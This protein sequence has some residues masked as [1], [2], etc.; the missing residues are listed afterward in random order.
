MSIQTF[1]KNTFFFKCKNIYSLLL[2]VIKREL[3]FD[4][5]KVFFR[6]H[7]EFTHPSF[8]RFYQ[9]PPVQWCNAYSY[10]LAHWIN[11]PAWINHKPF[12][13]EINDHPLSAVSYMNRAI[14][15]PVDMLNHIQDAKDVYMH[16]LCKKILVPDLGIKVLFR[17]YFGESFNKKVYLVKCPGC[18]P[19]YTDF[20]Q[21]ENEKYGVACFASDYELKGVDLV[22]KAWASINNKKRWRL[23]LACPNIPPNMLKEIEKQ[24]SIVLIN[25][26]PLSEDEK[27]QIL[28]N[29]SITVAPTHLHGGANII[30]G[31]EYGHAI[32][33]FETH[34]SSYA[35]LGQKILVPYHF[36][37]PKYYGVRWKTIE[38][39]KCA[40]RLDKRDE[41]F[42]C[43]SIDLAANLI[44]LMEDS[45]KLL[46]MRKRTMYSAVG[47]HSLK[48]RNKE[49]QAIY[50]E[51]AYKKPD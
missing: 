1:A 44:D 19:K 8:K 32:L 48:Q 4:R 13:L 21:I 30:E 38:D 10:K 12:I 35:D 36:Y 34:S 26:A 47:S 29:C 51:L 45:E 42:E 28:S 15:E 39:F 6:Y 5:P 14:F 43:V 3:S 2:Q 18:I 17:R 16:D 7:N 25:K 31:M 24:A 33:Y 41:Y 40:L 23:Y 46:M 49:L 50:H 9:K 37:D 11:Y 22:L 20:S 27:K